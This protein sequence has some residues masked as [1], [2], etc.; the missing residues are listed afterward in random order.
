MVVGGYS[1]IERG[2]TDI[3]FSKLQQIAKTFEIELSDL[4][5]LNEKNV[6]NFIGNFNDLTSS[7]INCTM[8]T[9]EYEHELEKAN[10]TIEHLREQIDSLKEMIEI[11]KKD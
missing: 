1:K 2:E 10:L 3:R 7:K 9:T 4:I 6:F 5:G 8:T 11:L